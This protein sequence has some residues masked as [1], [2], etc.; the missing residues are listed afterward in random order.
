MTA[1]LVAGLVALIVALTGGSIGWQQI[2][3]HGA[4]REKRRQAERERDDAN[5]RADATKI[6]PAEKHEASEILRRNL[7]RLSERLHDIQNGRE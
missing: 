3:A 1:E 5:A 6:P 7:A 2:K 4:E